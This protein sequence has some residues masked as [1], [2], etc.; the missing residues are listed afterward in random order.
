MPRK[1]REFATD[2]VMLDLALYNL[3]ELNIEWSRLNLSSAEAGGQ[4]ISRQQFITRL[5][6]K[7]L[8]HNLQKDILNDLT[9]VENGNRKDSD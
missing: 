6:K 7:A 2:R 3:Q 1:K 5:L 4:S 9:G 8:S